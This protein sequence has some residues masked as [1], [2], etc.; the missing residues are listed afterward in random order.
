MAGPVSA[1]RP[2]KVKPWR[3]HRGLAPWLGMLAVYT[4]AWLT[5][6]AWRLAASCPRPAVTVPA[7]EFHRRGE[8]CLGG[9]A[10]LLGRQPGRRRYIPCVL[11]EVAVVRTDQVDGRTAEPRFP[12]RPVHGGVRG[13]RSIDA[14]HDLA[15][16]RRMRHGSPPAGSDGTGYQQSDC[17][18]RSRQG[19]WSLPPGRYV[20][21]DVPDVCAVALCSISRACSH[22]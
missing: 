15:A 4:A 22:P 7:G 9:A 16:G 20:P 13:G 10:L 6:A 14:N 19:R 12:Y 18:A 1:T 17:G 8:Q 5:L 3:V 2:V 21:A 11:P